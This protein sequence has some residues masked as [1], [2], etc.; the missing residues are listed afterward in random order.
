MTQVWW[1]DTPDE[2]LRETSWER[3]MN[4]GGMEH[5]ELVVQSRHLVDRI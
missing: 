2:T 4:I 1:K 5:F 3:Q